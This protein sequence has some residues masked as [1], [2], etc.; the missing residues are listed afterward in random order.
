ML[1]YPRATEDSPK[2]QPALS[3]FYPGAM[4]EKNGF[5][6]EYIDER[7]D[8]VKL[9]VD[10]AKKNPLAIGVSAMTGFQLAEAKRILNTIKR[11]NPCI[12]TIMGG[13]HASLLPESTLSEDFVD[14]VIAGEGEETLLD[15]I[16]QLKGDKGFHSVKG[17]FWKQ[18][19]HVVAN[20]PRPFMDAAS[21]PFPL[22]AKTRPYFK[23]AAQAGE[24]M[25]PTSRGC[26][27][28][29]TFCYNQVFNRGRWRPFPLDKWEQEMDRLVHELDFNRMET[30]DDNI[31]RSKKRIRR[32][33]EI[34]RRHNIVWDTDMRPEYIDE[35]MINILE[36]GEC[37]TIFMGIESGSERILQDIIHKDLPNGVEDLKRCSRLLGKSGI[38]GIY[39]FMCN[40]PTENN[41]ELA[42]SMSLA[43]YIEERDPKA[44]ISFYVYAPY[45]GT[46]LYDTALKNGFK[47]PQSIDEWS[48]ITLSNTTNARS[49]SLYYISGLRFRG[50]KGDNT[51]RN[52]PGII[53]LL[54]LPF[55]LI[56]HLRW[57]LRLLS[58]YKIEKII[59]K[60]LF[61]W[62]SQR[63]SR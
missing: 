39:S 44:R 22:T 15:L 43:D 26:P 30:G 4:L 60:S 59:V 5:V 42:A 61:K 29:C 53:R 62:A 52:F 51:D 12:I 21:I 45:P 2:K 58:F 3:I 1:V 14:F 37:S 27:H 19:G 34:M 47:E 55:E 36:K 54:I 63:E 10:L 46:Y 16:T 48:K 24:M 8:D 49:E 56:A 7:F 9:I 25:Y 50:K 28:R 40:I 13:V 20:D 57:R 23:I 32:I 17:L 38:R 35:E 18:D 31:G 6:V 41:G 33:G 11:I